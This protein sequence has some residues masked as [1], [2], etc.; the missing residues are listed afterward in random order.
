MKKKQAKPV[1]K[2]KSRSFAAFLTISFLV[3]GVWF[4]VNMKTSGS[5]LLHDKAQVETSPKDS[6][7]KEY[8]ADFIKSVVEY[9]STDKDIIR[10]SDKESLN[11]ALDQAAGCQNRKIY[12]GRRINIAITG[13]DSRL[14][15]HTRHADANHVLSILLDSGKIEITSIPRDTPAD[16]GFDDST[17]QNK[18]T[19]VR[20]V[21][22]R[23]AY[24][25]ELARIARLDKIHYY[26]EFGFSQAMGILEWLGYGNAP[27]TLQVLRSR[28]GLGGDD[29]QR[30]YN[31]AQFIRQAMLTH[32]G[33]FTGILGSVYLRGGLTMVE[34]NMTYDQAKAVIEALESIGYPHDAS[35]ITI[36]VRPP[37][38]IKFKVYDFTDKAVIAK[39]NDRIESFNKYTIAKDSIVS[40]SPKVNVTQR[41]NILLSKAVAD[42]AKNP[43]AVIRTL[44]TYFDQRAWLQ[45]QDK[46]QRDIIRTKFQVLLSNA[47]YKK[48]Q[49]AKAQQIKDIIESE[50]KIFNTKQQ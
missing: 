2:K 45:V 6:S 8:D 31:Q 28:K 21:K 43:T 3:L 37:I 20:A 41:L 16:A 32:F 30:V 39:L 15:D 38:P 10:V 9:D 49:N 4:F 11:M 27:S 22:G 5:S 17:G 35:D 13:V 26:V 46:S 23:E 19:I 44:S 36:A 48:K 34:T 33:K 25:T 24:L 18:L 12:T 47:Y 42:S 50:K 29:Y 40:L 14:G 1:E 7:K